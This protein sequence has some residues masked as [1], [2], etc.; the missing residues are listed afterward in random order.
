MAKKNL[1]ASL[2]T[3]AVQVFLPTDGWINHTRRMNWA[4]AQTE[5]QILNGRYPHFKVRVVPDIPIT[6]NEK[7]SAVKMLT[8]GKLHPGRFTDLQATTVLSALHRKDESR[9]ELSQHGTV[10]SIHLGTIA[11]MPER[12]IEFDRGNGM[13]EDASLRP[14][15]RLKKGVPTCVHTS[16]HGDVCG[17]KFGFP[18]TPSKVRRHFEEQ[19]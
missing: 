13:P 18:V 14:L 12:P 4:D 8:D 3:Y 11:A 2:A 5:R 1:R 15:I 16:H 9:Y 7:V 19:H 17:Y 10:P 6:R